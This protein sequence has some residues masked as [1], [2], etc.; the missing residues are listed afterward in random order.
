MEMDSRNL[1]GLL[2]VLVLCLLI[3]V[4][5]LV[6]KEAQSLWALLI[7]LWTVREYPWKKDEGRNRNDRG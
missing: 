7:V 4:V 6:T 1:I 3:G 5:A 2:I